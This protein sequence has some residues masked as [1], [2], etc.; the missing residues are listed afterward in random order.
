MIPRARPQMLTARTADRLDLYERSVQ[1]PDAEVEFIDRVFTKAHDRPALTLRE[2]FCG[3][4][5]LCAEWVKSRRERRAVG[6]DLHA[7]TLAYGREHH[8]APLGEAGSRV[9][10]RRQ[11]VL[12]GTRER[13]DVVVAFNFSYCVFKQ[14]AVLARYLARAKASLAPGGVFM[15]DIYGGPDA[16]TELVEAK[17]MRGFTY[18]WDQRPYDALSAEA[19]RY[20]HFRFR[21]GSE[22][23]RAFTYDWRIWSL[24]ELRDLLHEAGFSRVEVYWEGSDAKG[25]GNGVFRKVAR[26]QNEQAWIAYVLAWR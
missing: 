11:D 26:A 20:I 4:G 25:R 10:L 14:R 9:E 5:F 12:A 1:A 2:D 3:T 23:R 21:D 13:F 15:L 6:L 16:Q 7:P 8:V 19:V 22:M 24:P 17:R 18:V